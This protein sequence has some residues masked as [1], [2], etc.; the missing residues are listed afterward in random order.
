MNVAGPVFQPW[1]SPMCS[2][3]ITGPNS[4]CPYLSTTSWTQGCN[5]RGTGG[6]GW[7][8]TQWQNEG[9]ANRPPLAP[10]HRQHS[11]AEGRPQRPLRARA[12]VAQ[13]Q[14]WLPPQCPVGRPW[15]SHRSAASHLP[16]PRA[17]ALMASG[18]RAGGSP[19]DRC[20]R[21][22]L[23]VRQTPRCFWLASPA[24]APMKAAGGALVENP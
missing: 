3:W 7:S 10:Y 22:R 4:P 20:S 21:F 23:H 12:H 24:H 5:Y 14:G 16:L 11:Q 17:L 8:R 6:G 15:R 19:P 13:C 1:T 2:S 18:P 9:G